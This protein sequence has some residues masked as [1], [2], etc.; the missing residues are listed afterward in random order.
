MLG[1]IGNDGMYQQL[2][3]QEIVT[4]LSSSVMG[5][6]SYKLLTKAFLPERS[7][8]RF[9]V[10]CKVLST[11]DVDSAAKRISE[12]PPLKHFLATTKPDTTVQSELEQFIKR[13]NEAAHSHVAETVSTEE[14]K[15]TADFIEHLGKSIATLLSQAIIMR[16]YTLGLLHEIGIVEEVAYAGFVVITHLDGCMLQRGDVFAFVYNKNVILATAIELQLNGATKEDVILSEKME[17]GIKF[18]RK[19][20]KGATIFALHDQQTAPHQILRIY[21]QRKED[22][23]SAIADVLRSFPVIGENGVQLALDDVE[24]IEIDPPHLLAVSDTNADLLLP[25][26]LILTNSDTIDQSSI[27]DDSAQST[28][29]QASEESVST[30]SIAVKCKFI[31]SSIASLA[32]SQSVTIEITQV[33]NHDITSSHEIRP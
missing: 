8:Y 15:N 29:Q 6:T 33:N 11:L 22:I 28:D 20:K 3:E 27:E 32:E 17:V 1:K 25:T 19:I 14:I 7:N 2:S 10:I 23:L 5:S 13:R 26:R 21:E 30:V 24:D 12:D 4:A 31:F 18:D 9:D 16:Q